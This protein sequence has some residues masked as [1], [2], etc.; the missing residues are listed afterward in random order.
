MEAA[1]HARSVARDALALYRSERL[2]EA[3]AKRDGVASAG[4]DEG[5]ER[6]QTQSEVNAA[7][8]ALVAARFSTG[9]EV[10]EL[11][12]CF[13]DFSHHSVSAYPLEKVTLFLFPHL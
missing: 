10:I 1:V 7:R 2:N 6:R 4:A 5:G 8:K 3:R 11:A 13:L 9:L 12:V